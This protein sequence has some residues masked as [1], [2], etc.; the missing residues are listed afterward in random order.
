VRI[1][2]REIVERGFAKRPGAVFVAGVIWFLLT[3]VLLVVAVFWFGRR[4]IAI[5]R[6]N[7]CG[8]GCGCLFPVKL[9]E[10]KPE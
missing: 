3:P 4:H 9:P 1:T 6:P 7:C 8:K 5:R 10:K 2:A